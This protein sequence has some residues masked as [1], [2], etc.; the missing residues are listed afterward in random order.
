MDD[1]GR[2]EHCQSCL[3]IV[4]SKDCHPER[5]E[6]TAELVIP[7]SQSAAPR[8]LQPER[9]RGDTPHV[10]VAPRMSP[11]GKPRAHKRICAVVASKIRT[12]R[13]RVTFRFYRLSP[14]LRS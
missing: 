12:R 5:R 13:A 9:K 4:F 8:S 6:V 11:V 3:K 1:K 7:S 10:V 14:Q 2:E